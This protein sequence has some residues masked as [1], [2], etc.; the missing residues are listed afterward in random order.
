[1][2]EQRVGCQNKNNREQVA[3]DD[4]GDGFDIYDMENAHGLGLISM[5]ERLRSVGGEFFIWSRPSL[6]SQV[7]GTV[8]ATRK[9][10]RAEDAALN[11]KIQRLA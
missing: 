11:E 5:R 7:K 6:G 8:P 3:S 4:D 2:R 1:M 10:S 9:L